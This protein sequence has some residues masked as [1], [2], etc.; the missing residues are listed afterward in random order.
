MRNTWT[1]FLQYFNVFTD[2]LLMK[3]LVW[4]WPFADASLND[5]TAALLQEANLVEE[6]P[7]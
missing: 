3:G 5:T 1:G 4:V 7:S 2:E 6:Q